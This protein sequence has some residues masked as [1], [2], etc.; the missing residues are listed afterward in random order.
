M[1][2]AALDSVL[3]SSPQFSTVGKTG[4]DGIF[5][6]RR[7]LSGIGGGACVKEPW[8]VPQ[9]LTKAGDQ[10]QPEQSLPTP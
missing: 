6:A 5:A 2:D 9:I 7:L 3:I 4:I 1:G 8:T 10:K